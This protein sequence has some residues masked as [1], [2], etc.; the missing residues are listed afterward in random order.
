MA[1]ILVFVEQ[2]K[3][4]IRNAS[5]QA[6]SEAKRQGGAVSAVLPGSGIGE[7]AAVQPVSRQ[8]V[9]THERYN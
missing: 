5:L 8:I 9:Q 2:R 4:E 1:G 3:S 6:L 7:A